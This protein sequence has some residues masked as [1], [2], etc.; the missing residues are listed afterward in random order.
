M[1]DGE[2]QQLYDE[3]YEVVHWLPEYVDDLRS[4]GSGVQQIRHI[5]K[6]LLPKLQKYKEYVTASQLA[7]YAPQTWD[8]YE[9]S[10]SQL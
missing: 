9:F 3:I 5:P 1:G 2:L 7:R 8:N 6:Y 4:S 10:S